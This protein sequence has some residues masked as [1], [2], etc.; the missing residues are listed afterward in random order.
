MALTRCGNTA[1]N[2]KSKAVAVIDLRYNL[3]MSRPGQSVSHLQGRSPENTVQADPCSKQ[4][5]TH[6]AHFHSTQTPPPATTILIRAREKA[7]H[8]HMAH[9]TK[10]STEKK[11]RKVPLQHLQR[12]SITEHGDQEDILFLKKEDFMHSQFSHHQQKVP[13]HL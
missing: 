2:M 7:M 5:S 4:H 3:P 10:K 1:T 11:E 6:R 13:L 9:S 12:K 8:C